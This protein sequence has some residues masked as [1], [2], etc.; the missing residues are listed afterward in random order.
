VII[1]SSS[2]G[3]TMSEIQKGARPIPNAAV[4]GHRSST[5]LI[6]LARSLRSKDL[7]SDQSGARMILHSI[8][9]RTCA[10]NKEMPG[11]SPTGCRRRLSREIYYLVAEVCVR[12]PTFRHPSLPGAPACAGR[13]GA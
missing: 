4:I 12:P 10:V 13:Y 3:L 8:G 6:P 1:A 11:M 9:Q 5:P 7:G 2:S